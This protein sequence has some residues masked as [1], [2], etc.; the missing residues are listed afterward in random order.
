MLSASF[1]MEEDLK[2]LLEENLR[3]AKDN[4]HMLR[5][6]RRAARLSFV[7]RIVFWIILLGVPAYLYVTYVAPVIS[8][9][10]PHG[11]NTHPLLNMLG[12]PSTEMLR[13]AAHTLSS[14]FSAIQN[15]AHST[16]L[17]TKFTTK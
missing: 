2:E 4:N 3:L 8:S 9:V 14:F 16:L 6:M 1:M 13:Q 10:F 15:I 17:T 5:S 7:G 12:I 11:T